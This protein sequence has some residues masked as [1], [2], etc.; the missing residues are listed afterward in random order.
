[1]FEEKSMS[2]KDIHAR[3]MKAIM[4]TRPVHREAGAPMSDEECEAAWKFVERKSLLNEIIYEMEEGEPE[5]YRKAKAAYAYL[6]DHPDAEDDYFRHVWEI[7]WDLSFNHG[8]VDLIALA[9][10]SWLFEYRD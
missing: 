3:Q 5:R 4:E 8:A 1:M 2:I 10:D 7:Y 6:K 9:S